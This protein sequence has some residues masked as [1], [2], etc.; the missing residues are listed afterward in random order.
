MLN[1]QSAQFISQE[2]LASIGAWKM[3]CRS[4]WLALATSK[5]LTLIQFNLAL[6]L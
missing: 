5:K 2:W 6:S 1:Q 4:G 3:H